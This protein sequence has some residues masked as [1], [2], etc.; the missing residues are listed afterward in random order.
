MCGRH[1]PLS[2]RFTQASLTVQDHE[3]QDE[4]APPPDTEML[5]NDAV[6]QANQS[7][8]A[9][10]DHIQQ[11]APQAQQPSAAPNPSIQ[12]NFFAAALAQAMAALP[13]QQGE[14]WHWP[15]SASLP[16]PPHF[17]ICLTHP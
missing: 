8:G 5:T 6:P 4:P 17:N 7:T 1:G 14:C 9:S 11:Q 16:E 3:A 2:A 13:Q 10:N 15:G 12:S